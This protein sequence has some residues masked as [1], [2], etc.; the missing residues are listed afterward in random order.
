MVDSHELGLEPMAVRVGVD[1][2]GGCVRHGDKHPIQI[3]MDVPLIRDEMCGGLGDDARSLYAQPDRD[4]G[5]VPP[6]HLLGFRGKDD[7]LRVR[8]RAHRSDLD[9]EHGGNDERQHQGRDGQE[10]KASSSGLPP[11]ARAWSLPEVWLD[12]CW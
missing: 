12:M 10:D 11:L 1:R 3:E 7:D 6:Q 5:W 4:G 2:G 8:R 9:P